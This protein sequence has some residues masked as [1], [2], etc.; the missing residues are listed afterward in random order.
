MSIFISEDLVEVKVRY[1]QLGPN[2][3]V[4]IRTEEEKEFYEKKVKV[5]TVKAKYERPGWKVFNEYMDDVVM[6]QNDIYKSPSINTTRLKRDKFRSLIIYL[7][8]DGEAIDLNK[9]NLEKLLIPDIPLALI[10]E[11]DIF[12]QEERIGI[13]KDS[14]ILEELSFVEG[15][16]EE[17]EDSEKE[18]EKEKEDVPEST[19][20]EAQTK[21]NVE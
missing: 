6:N 16:D 12:L 8:D 14:G 18:S 19:E 15:G 9:P 7:E 3:L 11:Y 20:K 17:G 2:D 4:V 13:L 10:E 21:E 5:K 1:A